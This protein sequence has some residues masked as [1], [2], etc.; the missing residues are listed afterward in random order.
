M[1]QQLEDSTV[2][3]QYQSAFT[4]A[5]GLPLT[6]LPAGLSGAGVEVAESRGAY[7]VRGCMGGRSGDWCSR[8]LGRAEQ[9]ALQRMR[10]LPFHCPAGL[11]KIIVPVRI[12]GQH[13]GNLL[14]GPFALQ[15]LD[16]RKLRRIRGRLKAFKLDGHVSRLQMTWR[17]CPLITTQ[18]MQAVLTLASMFAQYVAERGNCLVLEDATRS[19]SIAQRIEAVLA[20][21]AANGV[22]LREVAREVRLSP[23]HFCRLFKKQTGL[24]FTEYRVRRQVERA[25]QL[26]LDPRLRVSEAAYQAG[27]GSIPY[28]NRAFRRYVGYSPS[29]YRARQHPGNPG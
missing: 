1:W 23:C 9:R 4:V 2:L 21:H 15:A 12:A 16:A 29:E 13:A 5:T 24:T 27:F 7:C 22:S 6:L 14:A 11:V 25:R 17:H 28:F 8:M 3:R 19:S 18:K 26:L 10:P 20:E